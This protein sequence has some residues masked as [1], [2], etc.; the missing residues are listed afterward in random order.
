[1]SRQ[2]TRVISLGFGFGYVEEPALPGDMKTVGYYLNF[3]P[4]IVTE[5]EERVG[6]HE[7]PQS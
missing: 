7:K 5:T 3:C 2:D 4:E 6:I 1:M